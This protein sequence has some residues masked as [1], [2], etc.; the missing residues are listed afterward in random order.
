MEP[1]LV[2]AVVAASMTPVHLPHAQVLAAA[3]ALTS[4]AR[5]PPPSA[6]AG[7]P[8]AWLPLLPLVPLLLVSQ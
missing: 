1:P 5:H 4:V 7:R 3:T 6:V 8:P 2:A